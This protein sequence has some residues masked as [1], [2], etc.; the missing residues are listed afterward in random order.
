[1]MVL[2]TWPILYVHGKI[3]HDSM[4]T[5]QIEMVNI[6]NMHSIPAKQ[7]VNVVIVSI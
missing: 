6:V 3:A 4:L 2:S 7:Q 1:M 5:H